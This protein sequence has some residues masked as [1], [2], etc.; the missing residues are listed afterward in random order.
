MFE[1]PVRVSQLKDGGREF[2]VENMK[3]GKAQNHEIAQ[4][5]QEEGLR[6][7]RLEETEGQ[8]GEMLMNQEV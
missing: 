3:R 2:E 6:E 8:M 4:C 7:R 1:K 5:C